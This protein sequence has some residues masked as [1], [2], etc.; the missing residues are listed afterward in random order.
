MMFDLVIEGANVVTPHRTYPANVGVIGEKIAA[1]DYAPMDGRKV[2]NASGKYLIPGAIDTH[3][4]LQPDVKAE[5]VGETLPW[6][7][8]WEAGT[9]AAAFGGVT[10]VLDMRIQKQRP[11]E[12]VMNAVQIG[13]D[14]ASRHAAVDFSFHAALTF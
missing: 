7:D 14:S 12:T 3:L 9:K 8:G 2:I 10:T 4:H 11:G 13:L 1:I 6:I 5:E